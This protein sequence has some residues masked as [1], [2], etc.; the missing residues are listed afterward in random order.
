MASPVILRLNGPSAQSNSSPRILR[1]SS[2]TRFSLLETRY[3]HT[4]P[5]TLPPPDHRNFQVDPVTPFANA[6]STANL[7]GS[8]NAFLIEQLGFGHS[9]LAQVSSCTMGVI[10]SFIAN[11]TVRLFLV[12]LDGCE[13]IPT[14]FAIFFSFQ[15]ATVLSAQWIILISSLS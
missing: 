1:R 2:T 10:S 6:R 13:L 4:V 3:V 7:L 14:G 15:R 12:M 5:P 9:S 8:D 11:A